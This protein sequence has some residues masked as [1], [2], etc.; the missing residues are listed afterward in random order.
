MTLTE[1]PS[2]FRRPSSK[3]SRRAGVEPGLGEDARQL[4]NLEGVVSANTVA[5]LADDLEG[6]E[7]PRA[8]VIDD[9][10]LTG[11]T[12]SPRSFLVA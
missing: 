5:A 3:P 2:V 6:F 12:R 4:L 10:H 9:F 8:L 7:G 11:A 1:I